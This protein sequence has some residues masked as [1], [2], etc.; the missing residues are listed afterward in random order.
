MQAYNCAL[1]WGNSQSVR[2]KKKEKEKNEVAID[3]RERLR[4]LAMETVDLSKDPSAA[5]HAGLPRE[6]H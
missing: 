3:R 1:Y 4:R 2:A 6:F 5:R